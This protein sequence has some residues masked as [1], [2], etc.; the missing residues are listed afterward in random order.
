MRESAPPPPWLETLRI[1][2]REFVP[3]DVDGLHLLDSDARVLMK[4]GLLDRGWGHY[5]DKRL[6]LFAATRD[7]V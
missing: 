1:A 3:A 7:G 5:Y 6:R 2:L 4:A